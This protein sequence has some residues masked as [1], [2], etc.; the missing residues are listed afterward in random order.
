MASSQVE[1]ASCAPF[2]CVL[3]D[4][5]RRDRCR[6]E[7]NARATQTALQKNLK[8]LVRNHLQTCVSIPPETSQNQQQINDPDSSWIG[9]NEE[10]IQNPNKCLDNNGNRI[11]QRILGRSG[12]R[13]AKEMVPTIEAPQ[14]NDV[15]TLGLANSA[16]S[17]PGP[18]TSRREDNNVLVRSDSLGEISSLRASS[19]VQIWERR[20]SK[21]HSMNSNAS[22]CDSGTS[23]N[24]IAS[25]AASSVDE[26]FDVC[27]AT[28]DS[29]SAWNGERNA[30]SDQTCCSSSQ[31]QSLD[32]GESERVRVADIIRRFTA[33]NQVQSS[34][35]SL[36]D[37]NYDN[38]HYSSTNASPSGEHE[39]SS[40]P[41]QLEHR[42]CSPVRYSPRIRGRQAFND[43]P[44]QIERDR[45]GELEKLVD[46]RLVSRFPQKD[47]IQSLLRHRLEQSGIAIH[48]QSRSSQFN[49]QPQSSTIMHL[50]EQFDNGFDQHSA[51]AHSDNQADSRRPRR[52]IANDTIDSDNS[53]I[54]ITPNE[55]AHNHE[56]NCTEQQSPVLEQNSLSYASEDLQENLN[57]SSD[58]TWQGT[59]SETGNLESQKTTDSTTLFDGWYTNDAAEEVCNSENEMCRLRERRTVSNILCSS[60]RD[61]IDRLMVTHLERQVRQENE[62]ED[63]EQNHEQLMTFLQRRVHLAET[64]QQ[65]QQEL[66]EEE[67][68][69]QQQQQHLQ[70]D[71]EEENDEEEEEEEEQE[72]EG[73]IVISGKYQKGSDYINQ[74]TSS[75]Q[76]P[77]SSLLGSW[78]YQ[79]N[80]VGD[81]SDLATSTSPTPSPHQHL[82]SQTYYHGT[83]QCSPARITSSIEL[84]AIYD[85]RRHMEQLSHEMSELRKSMKVCM[86]MQMT[87][88][89]SI[90][91]EVNS[92]QGEG[93]SR[94]GA[95]KKGNCCICCEVKVDSLLYRCGHMCTCLKCAHEL[96]RS[97]GKCPICGA[98][99]VDV[100]RAYMDTNYPSIE[101]RERFD[102][103][104]D[105]QGATAHSDNQTDSRSPQREIANDTI[106]S[107]NSSIPITPNE[108]AHIHEA[109]CTEQQSPVLE[110]NSLSYASEDLQEN[111]NPS[112]D[113]IRQGTIS[114]TGNVESQETTD[115]TTLS[116]GW[117]TNDAVEEV[118]DN[119]QQYSE[120][121]YDWISDI[122]RP[123][124]HWED[125]RKAWYQKML[126][127]NSENEI[128]RLLE[129][130]TVSNILCSSF[131]D[132][133]DRLMVTHLERQV[134]QENEEEDEEQNHEQLMT[135]LQRRVHLAETQQQHQQ[136][137]EEEEEQEQQQ[138]QH[139][140]EDEEEENDEEEEEEE[141]QEQEGEIVISGQYQKGS[142][143]INQS[144]SSLQIPPSSLLG[145]WGYQDNEV[146]DESDLATSTSP[147][148]SPHQHLPSQSYIH[149]TTQ[150]SPARITSSIELEAIYDLRRHMEQLSHE[151]SELRKSINVCMD[152]QTTMQQSIKQEVNSVQGEGTSREGAPKKGNCCIC[153]EVF[154]F[155]CGHMCTCL[156]CAHELQWSSGKC[157]ICGAP[158]VDVVRAYKDT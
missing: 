24:E 13:D 47:Q 110:Q 41:D 105:Q 150:C 34:L 141:E 5:N 29:F 17:S 44:M 11:L 43:L 70:E 154:T 89:Q 152:M 95:P 118:E 117:D 55:G 62:E 149:G 145:S 58:V 130:R 39:R 72:Q 26:R 93:T 6:A 59:I 33:A 61:R 69:E 143:Y 122:S 124:S 102:N 56:A 23:C 92:A 86:D 119:Y 106:D 12:A 140:Q 28:E 79:D 68:Q 139:L 127:C 3:R 131:R 8:N 96:Q 129:R 22:R 16:T 104:F 1:M 142:D 155:V 109:N 101:S 27:P 116:D 36:S 15:D 14:T 125:R 50:R 63:E 46:R 157:P 103:G 135:F 77:P 78:G 128:C 80:E 66:E 137:L 132:R 108:G 30:Q 37:D 53:S 20:L 112:S 18:S 71:E 148:P 60:F 38:E 88:Q 151:M 156:K 52:E 32:S 87:M 144:T 51:K 147:T 153:Y 42:G 67:E 85:L 100:V 121:N 134:R 90:K 10:E 65:H 7:S 111:L 84:E 4:H 81:E 107:D 98:P 123:R 74:S 115:S 35:S 57:P 2:G 9:N 114:E 64:Q 146:G 97:S 75:L 99:I 83:T 54:P 136:E 91:Q 120:T 25:S 40:T 113:V 138:Q 94:E 133:I 48:P 76:I 21:S 82:P 158:I 19:L 45:H 126:N 49:K 73:E 31:E